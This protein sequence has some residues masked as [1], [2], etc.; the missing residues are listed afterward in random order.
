MPALGKL[1]AKELLA[2]RFLI[3]EEEQGVQ[4]GAPEE[5]KKCLKRRGR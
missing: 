4:Q 3:R 2:R 1:P 5:T